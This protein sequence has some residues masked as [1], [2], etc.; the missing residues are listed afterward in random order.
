[1]LCLWHVT[2]HD[3][4]YIALVLLKVYDFQG[5]NKGIIPKITV[6]FTKQRYF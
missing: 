6:E 5:Q 3:V 1:M 2:I 4:Q